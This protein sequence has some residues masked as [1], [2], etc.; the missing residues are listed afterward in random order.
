MTR[1]RPRTVW[2]RRDE[3]G[4][5]YLFVKSKGCLRRGNILAQFCDEDF[6]PLTGFSLPPGQQ[7]RVRLMVT[8]A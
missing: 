6:E 4:C 8:P 7:V 5:C 3:L 1:R 2:L